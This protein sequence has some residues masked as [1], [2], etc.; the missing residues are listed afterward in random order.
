MSSLTVTSTPA[1]SRAAIDRALVALFTATL[2]LSAALL[3]GVQPMFT[4][5]VLP[6]LGSSPSVWSLAVVFFQTALLA[7]YLYAHLS[8]RYLRF[9]SAVLLHLL[10][11]AIAFVALPIGVAKGFA[12]PPTEGESIWLIGLLAASVG[13]PFFAVAGNAPLLQA[14]FARSGHPNS[15]SPYFL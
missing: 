9:S 15:Q 5:M 10:V 4:K 13:L 2:F 3:F 6:R 7:G 11:L 12:R 8:T 14:W 1:P